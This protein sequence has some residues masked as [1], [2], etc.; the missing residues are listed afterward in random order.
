M[1]TMEGF[2]WENQI[3]KSPLS[4]DWSV[5]CASVFGTI[6]AC[7]SAMMS[8]TYLQRAPDEFETFWVTAARPLLGAAAGL[9]ALEVAGTGLIVGVNTN[10][11]Q[12]TTL[13]FLLGF[14]ERLIIGTVEKFEAQQGD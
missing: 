4:D 2:S 11:A 14:S 12:M 5:L 8:F 10:V 13:A 3:A 1:R 6:G 9:V 7:M